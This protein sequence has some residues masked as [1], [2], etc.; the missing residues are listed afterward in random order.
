MNAVQLCWLRNDLRVHDNHALWHASQN[1]PVVAACILTPDT[2]L[3]HD[4]APVKAD[5]WRRNLEQLAEQLKALN[6]PLRILQGESWSTAPQQLL[7][8][9]T[10]LKAQALFFNDEYGVH[11][12]QRDQAVADTFAA[13]GLACQRYTDLI[14]FKPGSLLTQSGSMFKVYSQFRKQAYQRLHDHLPACLPAPKKQPDIGISSDPVPQ[15]IAGYEAASA[16][17]QSLWPAGES[18]ASE[19]LTLFA[20]Q[21]MADYDSARDRP[22]VDGTSRLSA[23]LVSGVLSPRQCRRHRCKPG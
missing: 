7:A 22:D 10:E 18:A 20:E 2:W 6:I 15:Q 3:A 14:L 17:Q 11:E 5:F 4:D 9:A 13:E 16:Q 8:L 12:Q 23:Y 1:G 19:R 21:I